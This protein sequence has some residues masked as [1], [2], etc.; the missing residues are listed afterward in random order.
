LKSQ[1][2]A[3]DV[4]SLN[5]QAERYAKQGVP[6]SLSTLADQV[7]G[8][9]AVLMLAKLLEQYHRQQAG[10]AQ[11][12]PITWN[13]AGAWLIFSQSRQLNFSRTC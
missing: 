8:C 3:I 5:R 6:I 11:P 4:P 13:G 10:P 1:V 7:G 2:P 9:T 12:L